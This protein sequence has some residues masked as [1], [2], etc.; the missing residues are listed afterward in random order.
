MEEEIENDGGE[1]SAPSTPTSLLLVPE[2]ATYDS[3]NATIVDEPLR[4]TTSATV[5]AIDSLSNASEYYRKQNN[6]YVFKGI[7][8]GTVFSA[9]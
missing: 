6:N 1:R 8:F 5:S 2:A 7:P 4:P 3:T 9:E